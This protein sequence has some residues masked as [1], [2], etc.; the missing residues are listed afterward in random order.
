MPMENITNSQRQS[1][2]FVKNLSE[3]LNKKNKIFQLRG[4][5]NWEELE[6]AALAHLKV[7]QLGRNQKSHR[8]LLGLTML[9]AMGNYSD[10]AAAEELTENMYWQYF[11]G[12]EYIEQDIGVSES[13][14]RRFRQLLGE[15]GYNEILKEL[16]RI[17]AKVGV[18]KKKDL[19]SII[20]DTTVQIKNIKH[21]H[22]VHLMEKARLEI[23]KLAKRLDINLNETFA[24]VFK[25][26]TIKLWKYKEQSK[27]KKRGKIMKH[28][29]VLLGRLI[30][31]FERRLEENKIV[32]EGGNLE[33]YTKIKKIHAQS[34][35]SRSQ[36]EEYKQGANILY[37]YHAP[38]VECIGKGKLG[39][40]YEFV[41]KVGI[42]VTRRGN[43]VLC[44][45]SFHNN[46]YDG[47]TLAQTVKAVEDLTAEEVRQ[48]FVD[49]GYRGSNVKEKGKVYSPYTKKK[50]T[51]DDEAM[52][53]RSSAI[54]PVIGHLKQ[55]GRMG[56][57][58]LSG[59]IGDSLN[60][61]IS[62]I[63][64]NLR[65]IANRLLKLLKP[66]AAAT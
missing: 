42:A 57:N 46:P 21:P 15:A 25:R 11:C 5:I 48:M 16:A 36:K 43:F 13:C 45:K 8:V 56:R 28:L 20:V 38:E 52:M 39:K 35:L 54:E 49:L 66:Q 14:V 51:K 3:E 53:K 9:Q 22:D 29:K 17:G 23:V 60:P 65:S 50:L 58:R 2:I 7:R 18:F 27:A 59:I 55:Y 1:R 26:D 41:N 6:K 33:A 24:K 10:A 34:V 62:A 30:R 47:H 63:G 12:Y 64:F 37:S 61:L 40:P 4:L 32:L 44:A 31:I 19:Q